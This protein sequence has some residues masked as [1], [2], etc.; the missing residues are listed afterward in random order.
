[1]SA[2]PCSSFVISHSRTADSKAEGFDDKVDRRFRFGKGEIA[3]EGWTHIEVV[4]Q[5]VSILAEQRGTVAILQEPRFRSVLDKPDN[6]DIIALILITQDTGVGHHRLEQTGP[7]SL[8]L[9]FVRCVCTGRV[10]LF[11]S[12]WLSGQTLAA[13]P[14]VRRTW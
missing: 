8:L 3:R 12:G 7:N 11:D 5:D 13:A 2:V 10:Q 14:A 9:P 4:G 6:H 1:M